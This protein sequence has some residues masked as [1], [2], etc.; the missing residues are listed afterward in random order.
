MCWETPKASVHE[1]GTARPTMW[2]AATH[3]TPMWKRGEDHRKMAFSFH[4]EE[5]LVHPY[6]S[7]R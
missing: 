7:L 1:A 3:R 4:S 6:W 5:R 2:P